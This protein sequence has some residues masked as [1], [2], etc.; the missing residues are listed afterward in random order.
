MSRTLPELL[1]GDVPASPR[2]S[3]RRQW[4]DWLSV[5][6]AAFSIALLSATAPHAF[7][8]PHKDLRS[9]R[10]YVANGGS[11]TVSVID[12]RTNA[13]V[14]PPIH[15]G[16]GPAGVAVDSVRGRAYVANSGSGTVSVINTK[17]NTVVGSPIHVG[18]GPAGVAVDSVR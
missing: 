12:T 17:T 5:I 6:L 3:A 2:R 10:L 1:P 7:A 11:G 9:D 14:G 8:A 16:K 18:K 4:L 13:F 15:V